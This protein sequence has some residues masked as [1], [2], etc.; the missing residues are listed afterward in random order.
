[1][2]I[3]IVPTVLYDFQLE[4]TWKTYF[5]FFLS[6]T[7][8]HSFARSLIQTS[9]PQQALWK[10]RCYQTWKLRVALCI[11]VVRR[12][13]PFGH[14]LRAPD[15]D[16]STAGRGDAK[17]NTSCVN[18][19]TPL[20]SVLMTHERKHTAY[21]HYNSLTA[22]TPRNH[23]FFKLAICCVCVCVVYVFQ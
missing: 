21:S 2:K 15:T 14:V 10:P 16:R 18:A 11:V 23:F 1:M 9:I 4:A 7:L 5:T 8:T 17:D 13:L 12:T 20:S 22:G 19:G 3:L 6:H